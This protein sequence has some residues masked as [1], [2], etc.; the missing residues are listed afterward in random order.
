[1]F[2]KKIIFEPSA[3]Y[4]QKDNRIAEQKDR[5]LMEC[6]RCTIIGGRITDELWPEILLAITHISNLMPISS[7]YGVSP[8]EALAQS[9]SNLQHL[10][11]LGSIVYV[12]INKEE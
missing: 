4:F 2:G 9:L 3:P 11:I 12:F 8:F 6:M 7:L 5:R 10:C 1:M